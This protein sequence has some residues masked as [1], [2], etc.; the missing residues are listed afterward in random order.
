MLALSLVLILVSS[1]QKFSFKRMK[2]RL[3]ARRPHET[4][5]EPDEDSSAD[6]LK[7]FGKCCGKNKS[8]P[9]CAGADEDC[10][11]L[12]E[13]IK[14]GEL[15]EGDEDYDIAVP[16]CAGYCNEVHADYCGDIPGAATRMGAPAVAVVALV[17]AV[18]AVVALG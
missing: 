1:K 2:A 15:K 5:T 6:D 9:E 7:K 11:E 3:E 4:C 10:K 17:A 14:N 8:N 13:A 12:A 18:A 16:I